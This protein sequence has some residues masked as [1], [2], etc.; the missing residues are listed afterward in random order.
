M[1]SPPLTICP[2][3]GYSL[4]GDREIT[5]GDWTIDPRDGV[6][7]RGRTVERLT[8]PQIG[9]LHSLAKV[10]GRILTAETLGARHSEAEDPAGVVRVMVHRMRA[11]LKA[12]GIEP[13]FETVWRRGYRWVK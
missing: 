8:A 4:T 7:F 13:P 9:V 2:N 12:Q 11:T 5:V 1:T 6:H 10:A 3:C